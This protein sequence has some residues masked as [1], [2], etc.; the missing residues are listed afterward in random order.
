MKVREVI[1][2]LSKLDPEAETVT[3]THCCGYDWL[4]PHDIEVKDMYSYDEAFHTGQFG[5][6]RQPYL[7]IDPEFDLDPDDHPRVEQFKA[8]VIG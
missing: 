3:D 7:L 2:M 4:E 1:E 5:E 8:V 6:V